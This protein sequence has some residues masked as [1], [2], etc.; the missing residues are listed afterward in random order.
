ME[1]SGFASLQARRKYMTLKKGVWFLTAVCVSLMATGGVARAADKTLIE[2]RAESV[3]KAALVNLLA[4]KSYLMRGDMINEVQLPSGQR[5]ELNGTLQAALRRPDRAWTKVEGE[6]RKASNFYDGKTFTH[7]DAETN[8]YAGWA[9]PPTTDEMLDKL[10]EQLGFLP[11]L[12]MLLR[13]NIDKDSFA[14]VQT[15]LY[16]GETVVGGVPCSHL[17]FTQENMDWQVW[18]ESPVPM[19]KRIAITYKKLPGAPKYSVTF[20]AWNLNAALPDSVFAF[21]PPPGAT[22]VEFEPV[23]K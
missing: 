1:S 21:E 4:A 12:S 20:A 11:P 19:I 13:Q 2:P 14:S 10:K 16:L 17:A 7:Y 22:R 18:V 5:I 23:K 9:A 3:L 15:G 8:S 6:L